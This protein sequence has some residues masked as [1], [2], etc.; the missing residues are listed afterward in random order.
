MC[1]SFKVLVVGAPR[2]GKTCV[3]HRY[4]RNQFVGHSHNGHGPP[5]TAGVEVGLKVIEASYFYSLQLWECPAVDWQFDR[6]R[7]VWFRDATGLAVIVSTKDIESFKVIDEYA[8]ATTAP[9]LLLACACMAAARIQPAF[10]LCSVGRKPPTS[11]A[12]RRR[13]RRSQSLSS[14]TK[15]E[16]SGVVVASLTRR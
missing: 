14:P 9:A 12:Q 15:Y 11:T 10:V 2:V 8:A 4:L 5:P 16:P 6:L 13:C 7:R 1:R 3:M